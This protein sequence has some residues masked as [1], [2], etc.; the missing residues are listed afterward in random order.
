MT[1]HRKRR[2]NLRKIDVRHQTSKDHLSERLA[3][4]TDPSS[5]VGAAADYVRGS[6]KRAGRTDEAMAAA[7]A[8]EVV[9]YLTAVGDRILADLATEAT[10]PGRPSDVA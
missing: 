2:G 5:R 1:G 9:A 3:Q 7:V 6:L 4:F 10:R 8:A